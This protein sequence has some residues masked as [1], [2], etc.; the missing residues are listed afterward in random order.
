MTEFYPPI[1]T[2]ETLELIAIANGTL[3]DWQQEAIDQAKVELKNRGITEDYQKRFIDKWIEERKES[4]ITYQ[5]QLE[6]NKTASYSNSEMICILLLAP[7]I[8]MGKW[9]FGLSLSELKRENY[10]KKIKQRLLLLIGG[11]GFWISIIVLGSNFSENK[12][13]EDIEKVDIS[14]WEKNRYRTD[15][16][17]N[18]NN[19]KDTLKNE[20]I[21]ENGL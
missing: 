13:L 12:R 17:T 14:A 2:R 16:L 5:K 1:E 10:S 4:E 3:D 21:K 8:L 15:E 7:F 20:K 11:I 18:D 6:L 9:T 19:S